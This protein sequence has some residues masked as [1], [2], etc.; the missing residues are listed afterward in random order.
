MVLCAW[1]YKIRG[2]IPAPPPGSL[3]TF[4]K[5]LTPLLESQSPQLSNGL[6]LPALEIQ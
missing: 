3:V 2:Q 4:F 1:G 5:S 6:A